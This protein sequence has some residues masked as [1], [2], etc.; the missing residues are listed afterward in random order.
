MAKVGTSVSIDMELHIKAMHYSSTTGLSI[1][2]IL[3]EALLDFLD[4]EGVLDGIEKESAERRLSKGPGRPALSTEDYVARRAER[5][6][7]WQLHKIKQAEL[8]KRE[9]ESYQKLVEGGLEPDINDP[10]EWGKGS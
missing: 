9:K 8:R 5:Q 7:A 3:N 1:S 4:H 6:K 10:R 2:A